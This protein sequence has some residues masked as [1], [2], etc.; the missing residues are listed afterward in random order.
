[1]P[2]PPKPP[3]RCDNCNVLAVGDLAIVAKLGGTHWR[4]LTHAVGAPGR[5]YT[6]SARRCGV[7]REDKEA[8]R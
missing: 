5:N 3:L 4:I 7:W 6:R 2:E 1:M 8:A